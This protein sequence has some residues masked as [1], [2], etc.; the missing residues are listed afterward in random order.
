M[1]NT[2]TAAAAHLNIDL[3]ILSVMAEAGTSASSPPLWRSS[4]SSP[5]LAQGALSGLAPM[6]QVPAEARWPTR[7]LILPVPLPVTLPVFPPGVL[8][9]VLAVPLLPVSSFSP[10]PG[11]L[12]L[13]LQV[14]R[15]AATC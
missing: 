2:I 4:S 10:P 6:R 15:A 7:S 14:L 1:E 5:R 8:V 11:V 13:L 3:V 12:L 9:G